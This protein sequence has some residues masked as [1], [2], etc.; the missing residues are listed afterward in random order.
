MAEAK[1]T[2]DQRKAVLKQLANMLAHR[3]FKSSKRCSALLHY[4]VQHAIDDPT[5]HIKERILGIE[6]FA[7]DSDYDTASDPVVRIAANELRKRIAQYYHEVAS[8]YGIRIEMP[9]G[10]Y[11][12]EFQFDPLPPEPSLQAE[13]QSE[14][15]PAESEVIANVHAATRSSRSRRLLYGISA[16][17]AVVLLL[18]GIVVFRF[19]ESPF[20]RFWSPLLASHLRM[21]I[22]FSSGLEPRKSQINCNF[23]TVGNESYGTAQIP[24][25]EARSSSEHIPTT[26]DVGAI[27]KIVGFIGSKNKAYE[28]R[29]AETSTLE[30]LRAGPVVLVG[31]ANNPWTRCLTS[32]LRFHIED[33]LVANVIRV[34]DSND[35]SRKD[36]TVELNRNNA[37]LKKDYAI[38]SRY[39]DSLTGTP[40]LEIA[41]LRGLGT[42]AAAEFVSDPR[43]INALG[44]LNSK[45]NS[46][47][48]FILQTTAVGGDSGPPQVLAVHCW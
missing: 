40:V 25:S 36:W 46:N 21:L 16:A 24:K 3:S 12:P 41:G 47:V 10:T 31:V 18:C 9:T 19:Q 32:S 5:V 44:N 6:V 48:Q 1:L 22:C 35:A 13:T 28:L 11:T 8:E 14:K 15:S 34:V 20:A 29:S 4:L 45:C 43:Y 23:Q 30:D 27:S 37:E 17:F 42:A 33:D 39:A 26:N 38:V 2:S 7:R